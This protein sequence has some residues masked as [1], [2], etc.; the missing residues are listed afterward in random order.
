MPDIKLKNG[1]GVEQV[2]TGVDT[3]TVPLADGTGTHTFGLTDEDLTFVNGF[4]TFSYNMLSS[5]I[6]DKRINFQLDATVSSDTGLM[7]TFA[8][9]NCSDLSHI[10]IT[11][12]VPTSPIKISEPFAECSNL[13][14]LPRF[15]NQTRVR[16]NGN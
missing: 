1:S 16:L 6:N 12:L 2:Y 3:I 5:H 4:G 7:K 10:T 9:S 8:K 11:S 13:E 14:K 15:T